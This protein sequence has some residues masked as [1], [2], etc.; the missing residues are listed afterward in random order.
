[1][2]SL[3][4]TAAPASPYEIFEPRP[5]KEKGRT[6]ATPKKPKA[7]SHT[8][9]RVKSTMLAEILSVGSIE[10][11]TTLAFDQEETG[12]ELPTPSTGET[13]CTTLEAVHAV[14]QYAKTHS[15]LQEERV[16]ALDERMRA[17]L[18]SPPAE[19]FLSLSLLP[20]RIYD[21]LLVSTPPP[22]TNPTHK[23]KR[24]SKSKTA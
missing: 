21:T 12:H 18:Q 22:E 9:F 1:M 24:K 17:L 11:S 3:A 7:N 15:L 23:A 5:V 10:T 19:R 16:L 8:P 6:K 4:H 13:T 2:D 20:K 14:L